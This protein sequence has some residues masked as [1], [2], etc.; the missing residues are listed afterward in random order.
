MT[1][2]NVPY[3]IEE[4]VRLVHFFILSIDKSCDKDYIIM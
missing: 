2:L 4:R 1:L 3:I